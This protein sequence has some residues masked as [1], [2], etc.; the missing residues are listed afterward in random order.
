MYA[1]LTGEQLDKIQS[2]EK[3][4]GVYI[5]ATPKYKELSPNQVE[6]VTG[7]EKKLGAVLIAYET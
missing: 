5:L 4:L 1:T 2:L 7:L 6:E 3:E